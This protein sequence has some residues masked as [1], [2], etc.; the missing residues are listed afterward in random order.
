[1][2]KA[3]IKKAGIKKAGTRAGLIAPLG[4]LAYFAAGAS[5]TFGSASLPP[6]WLAM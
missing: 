4:R 6:D 3:G 1:M 2:K 5:G